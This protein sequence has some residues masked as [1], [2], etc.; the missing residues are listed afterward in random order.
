MWSQGSRKFSINARVA[1]RALL[2]SAL[3]LALFVNSGCVSLVAW[4]YNDAD[5]RFKL[6]EP[7]GPT[8]SQAASQALKA[9][10]LPTKYSLEQLNSLLELMEDNPAPELIYA[11]VETAYL[12]ARKH[13]TSRPKLARQLY[14]SAALYAYHYLFNPAL[15]TQRQNAVFNGHTRDVAL[16]YNGACER[17][18]HLVVQETQKN[19]AD[20]PLRSRQTY[21]LECEATNC[22]IYC[23]FKRG[24]WTPEECASFSVVCDSAVDQLGFDCN[25]D[26]LGAPLVAVRKPSPTRPRPE[27]KYYPPQICYPL[28]AIIRPNF[29]YPLGAIP[30]LAPGQE[31]TQSTASAVLELYDPLVDSQLLVAQKTIPL[32]ADLTTP[33]AHFL[34]TNSEM[35]AN[36]GARGLLKP[37]ELSQLI[38][39]NNSE[40]ER[41]LQGLY[42]LEPYDPN[43]IPVIMTHG[44]ASTPMTWME[45]YNA[46]R[47]ASEIQSAYQFWFFFYP[48]GQ[49]FWASAALMREEMAKIRTIVDPE[50]MNAKLDQIVLIGHSMGGLVSRMQV[51]D[52]GNR[53]W[54]NI[55]NVPFDQIDF[56]EQTREDAK[57]WFFFEPNPS[58]ACVITIAT[59][60]KGS[61]YSNGLTQ[62]VADRAITMPQNVLRTLTASVLNN[63]HDQ[64]RDP[65]LLQTTTSVE[66][67][68]PK[69]PIYS[70]LDSC[71]IPD[72]VALYNII[73]VLPSLQKSPFNPRKSDGVV[74]YWSSHRDDVLSERE[75]PS[76]HTTVHAHPAA[77]QEVKEILDSRLILAR[78]LPTATPSAVQSANGYLTTAPTQPQNPQPQSL[79]P[80]VTSGVNPTST[81]T[82]YPQIPLDP[83]TVALPPELPIV[84]AP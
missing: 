15:D 74:D 19:N 35:I 1:L 4:R 58:V 24:S 25:R 30:P 29:N 32:R 17:L 34:S 68:S 47:N 80:P 9:Y 39:T 65:T 79:A 27:E 16:L 14:I 78:N 36:T 63:R 60:F 67:L 46:L 81:S 61:E 28:T 37:E 42:L 52:S 49:P 2:V 55:A 84:P 26:G 53:I 75:V 57:K 8:M 77:I 3:M 20:F 31:P 33:L 62:W 83:V 12:Q 72:N 59:P 44:L 21:R 56:D 66:A 23:D 6:N 73:G 43:K 13:E 76:G 22:P 41:T 45:M 71:P 64:L 10:D 40:Q 11:Y 70:A 48:S 51:Q 54:D 38:P 69:S 82:A 7:S 5:L 50:H 18:L